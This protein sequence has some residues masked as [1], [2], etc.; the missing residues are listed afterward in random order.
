MTTLS[1][2]ALLRLVAQRI[3]GPGCTTAADAVRWM[4]ALQA[5]DYNGVL[6]SVALRT[7]A[8]TRAGVEAALSAG[9]V[10]KS[11]PMRG[12]LHLVVAE[13]LPWMLRI[14]APRVV[15][16]AAA[17]RAQLG[18]DPSTLERAREIAVQ[19]LNGDRQ[20]RRRTAR[21]VGGGWPGY[22]GPARLPHAVAPGADRNP[23]LRT[24]V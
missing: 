3:A 8:G 1:E 22:R 4:T 7:A 24:G 16:G 9:E 14:A 21:C 5:Q 12:T 6:T 23:V 19:A 10:V 2:V 20:L 15:A 11:W 17:R 18:L 13:D